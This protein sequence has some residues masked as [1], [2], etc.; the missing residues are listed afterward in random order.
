M[1]DKSGHL[2]VPLFLWEIGADAVSGSV[3]KRIDINH[4]IGM[5]RSTKVQR[6]TL[7]PPP[8]H[9]PHLCRQWNLTRQAVRTR[10]IEARADDTVSRGEAAPAGMPLLPRQ[11]PDC[12]DTGATPPRLAA[13]LAC[14]LPRSGMSM[15]MANRITA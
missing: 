9:V 1:R 2:R 8:K 4:D 7:S 10:S 15:S 3:A 13:F 14:R 5:D 12:R 6:R 11:M